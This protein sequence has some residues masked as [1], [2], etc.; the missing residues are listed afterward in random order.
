M[1]TG[2]YIYEE[3]V[4]PGFCKLGFS[5]DIATRKKQH[6]TSNPRPLRLIGFFPCKL[7]QLRH[8]ESMAKWFFRKFHYK[9]EWYTKDMIPYVQNFIESLSGIETKSD[10]KNQI[11]MT[12]YGPVTRYNNR[13]DCFFF[14][15]LK[16]GIMNHAGEGETYRTVWWP[17]AHARVF[18]SEHF[19]K[20]IWIPMQQQKRRQAGVAQ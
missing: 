12:V 7:N 16:A 8:Y 1:E 14:P 10:T 4:E 3:I 15:Q 20:K 17:D 11:V 9:G 6:K 13:P 19:H 2:I 18:V 5:K